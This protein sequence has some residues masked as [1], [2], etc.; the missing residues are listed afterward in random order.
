MK[1]PECN[2]EMIYRNVY[3]YM[4]DYIGEYDINNCPYNFCENCNS[5]LVPLQ[6]C[7]K[8]EEFEQ[9]KIEELLKKNFSTSEYLSLKEISEMENKSEE[10]VLNDHAFNIWVYHIN[11][12]RLYLKKSY[13]IHKNTGNIG[14]LKLF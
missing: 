2:N 4:D 9:I 6:S 13:E 8:I 14:F 5:E 12:P 3:H 1:C 7:L 11:N 10:N